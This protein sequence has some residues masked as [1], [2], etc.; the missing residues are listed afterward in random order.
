VLEPVAGWAR[1]RAV[2]DGDRQVDTAHLLHSLLE[3]DPEVVA[4]CGGPSAATRLLGYLIQRSI[5]FGL[6]WR[7][8]VEGSPPG[9]AMPGRG[10]P[11]W[12]PA[13]AAALDRACVLAGER[14]ACRPQGLDLLV[15]LAEERECRA[16]QVL[17]HAG[18][19]PDRLSPRAGAARTSPVTGSAAGIGDAV[20][21]DG[22]RDA[23]ADG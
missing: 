12:S 17:R 7:D 8:A 15:A 5:G 4:A 14:G 10:A 11:V 1:R 16:V 13:A 23:T 3:T 21:A 9:P 20:G 2:R 18:V 6:R 22:Q 19:D